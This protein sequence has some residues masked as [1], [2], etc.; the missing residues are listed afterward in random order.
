MKPYQKIL[1]ASQAVVAF[2]VVNQQEQVNA[3][4][5]DKTALSRETTSDSLSVSKENLE[6][7]EVKETK[8]STVTD[9]K[10]KKEGKTQSVS[11]SE[12]QDRSVNEKAKQTESSSSKQS[13]KS[14]KEETAQANPMVESSQGEVELHY[15]A[16]IENEGYTIDTKPWGEE[17]FHSANVGSSDDYLHQIVYIQKEDK[18]G[19][20]A[21]V[22]TKY[23]ELGWIDKRAFKGFTESTY[24]ARL[25]FAGYS[26]DTK[27]WGTTGYQT[28]GFT[29]DYLDSDVKVVMENE[30]RDYAL[31]VK[32]GQ[33]LGWIDKRS[34]TTYIQPTPT[35]IVR[36]GYSVDTKP[37][38]TAGFTLSQYGWSEG[39]L[40]TP[41]IIRRVDQ[42][43]AYVFITDSNNNG[44]GWIDRRALV[45]NPRNQK[46]YVTR[47]G[48]SLDTK[49]WG[50]EGFKSAGNGT[51][52][53]YIGTQVRIIDESDNGAYVFVASQNQGLG[54]LDKRALRSI[55]GAQS[56]MIKSPGYSLDTRPWGEEG[57]HSMGN[58]TSADYLGAQVRIIDASDNGAYVFVV[59]SSGKGLGW[60]D[61]RAFRAEELQQI[62]DKREQET[63]QSVD[64]V[65]Q[66]TG[67]V[68]LDSILVPAY[69]LANQNGLYASVMLAQAALESGW[70]RSSLSIPPYYNLFGVKGEYQ[71][72]YVSKP[73]LEDNGSG[74]YYQI[75]ARFRAYPSYRESLSDYVNLLK[76]GLTSNPRFYAPTWKENTNSYRDATRYLTGTYATDTHYGE[77][78]NA[79]IEQFNLTRYDTN[80]KQGSEN[81]VAAMNGTVAEWLVNEARDW[82]GVK[83]GSER[84]HELVDL[85]NTITPL[86][87]NYQL[88]Y[89]DAWCDAFVTV[90]AMKA[91]LSSLIGC[92]CGVQR[93]IDIFKEKGI[94]YEDG[95]IT[96][97]VGDLVAFSWRQNSQPNDN[98]ADH[99]GIVES[100]DPYANTFTTIEGNAGPES[101]VMRVTYPIGHGNIR[102]FARPNYPAF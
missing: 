60:L 74:E 2:A 94:W 35:A 101:K 4:Q 17:G 63:G 71:G 80:V 25:E 40:G 42:S 96:P 70:G 84:H 46:A 65:L 43:G 10:Q 11:S 58:G 24:E 95:T 45:Q 89:N 14:V 49:P 41:V 88:K 20:Y 21:N 39:L 15:Q 75:E 91:N 98:F 47:Y 64:A 29:N 54:W 79:I 44:M 36:A 83:M 57:F 99:I 27:P 67:N 16:E 53:D 87:L 48:Y 100:V 8:K 93:H 56:A 22:W 69:E 19:N 52:A 30:T 97:Q 33:E 102:G 50:E 12:F 1:L 3:A 68:F 7:R 38:G 37:W 18:D 6:K 85:Y 86:P 77:K 9:P 31:V 32:N 72:N 82:I 51:S 23:R 66:P 81:Q 26:I 13:I 90:M 34:L 61:T 62:I 73:T 92:E 5:V 59:D 78:L 76:N 55:E 28:K